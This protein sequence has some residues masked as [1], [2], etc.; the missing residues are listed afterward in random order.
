MDEF[1][2]RRILEQFPIIRS[3]AYHAESEASRESSSK[4]VQNEAVMKEW[5]N[6]WDEGDQ[7]EVEIQGISHHDAFWGKLK[8]AAEM[9]VCCTP[10]LAISDLLT[11]LH[12]GWGKEEG[13]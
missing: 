12:D 13:E 1:E 2:F 10:N 8:S 4:S 7:K 3:P 11:Y 6:A 9:K 5:Q